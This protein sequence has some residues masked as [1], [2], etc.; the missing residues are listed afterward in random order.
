ME[1]PF[2]KMFNQCITKYT[3]NITSVSSY[4]L[5]TSRTESYQTYVNA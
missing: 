5:L 3:P 2:N 1:A 4:I